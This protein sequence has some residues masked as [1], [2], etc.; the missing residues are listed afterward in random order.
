MERNKKIAKKR[1]QNEKK[2]KKWR[3]ESTLKKMEKNPKKRNEKNLNE[4]MRTSAVDRT[5]RKE[6]Q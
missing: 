5:K 6:N 4:I 1:D 3:Q 2:L